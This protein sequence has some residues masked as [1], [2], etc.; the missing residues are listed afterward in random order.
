MYP[1]KLFEFSELLQPKLSFQSVDDF[2]DVWLIFLLESED[3]IVYEKETEDILFINYI[4]LLKDLL[5]SLVF[6][7]LCK[8]SL[9]Q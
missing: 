4:Q 7:S 9:P 8:Y 6:Q 2:L 1:K 5:E 3:D